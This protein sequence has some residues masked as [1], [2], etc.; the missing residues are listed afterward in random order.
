[1][2]ENSIQFA[3]EIR[4]NKKSNH[5][6]YYLVVCL[7]KVFTIFFLGWTGK[8]VTDNCLCPIAFD[9]EVS[10]EKPICP[11]PAPFSNISAF[12][13]RL[14]TIKNKTQNCAL[15]LANM[16]FSFYEI[17]KFFGI[18]RLF[19]KFEVF[20]WKIQ[21]M[22]GVENFSQMAHFATDS[23]LALNSPKKWFQLF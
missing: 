7:G 15:L 1:M 4:S 9:W 11:L 18:G 17:L 16:F 22:G 19:A 8:L 12:F 14:L 5:F 13:K 20:W 3:S 2:G 23:W 10:H 6:K 21:I